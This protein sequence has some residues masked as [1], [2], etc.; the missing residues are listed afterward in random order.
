MIEI[1]KTK[2][3]ELRVMVQKIAFAC[4]LPPIPGTV[5]IIAMFWLVSKYSG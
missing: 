4:K 2:W 1:E 5:N 3:K